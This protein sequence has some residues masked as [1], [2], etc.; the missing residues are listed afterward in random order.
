M[1]TR[2]AAHL[3]IALAFV[4]MLSIPAAAQTIVVDA[5]PHPQS[6]DLVHRSVDI[7]CDAPRADLT[8]GFGFLQ[9]FADT[10]SGEG[11]VASYGCESWDESGP[12]HVYLVTLT[13]DAIL[14]AVLAGNTPDHDLILLGDCHSDSCL[15]QANTELTAWLPAGDY[16]LVVDGYLGASGAYEL[17]LATREQGLPSIVCTG[18]QTI[19]L[20]TMTGSEVGLLEIG[21]LFEQPDLVAFFDC[22]IT[23]PLGGEQWYRMTLL[24]AGEAMDDPFP[25]DVSLSLTVTPDQS[26]LDLA[27]WL[28]AGCGAEAVCLGYVDDEAS[29][30]VE[31]ISVRN[32]WPEPLNLYVAVDCAEAPD[33]IEAGTFS[34]STDTSVPIRQQSWSDIRR[35]FH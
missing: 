34:L 1:V 32:E 3:C 29:G 18:D 12:E 20:G 22:A 26:G 19:D 4:A 9:S 17:T 21:S 23:A 35:M 33:S 6:G 25:G 27:V 11:A 15:A 10:T 28:F 13:T 2:P 14:D 16:V 8:M 31:R 5:H 24:A 7:P 30:G